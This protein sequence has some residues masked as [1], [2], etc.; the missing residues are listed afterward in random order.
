MSCD[1]C[2]KYEH[3]GKIVYFRWGVANIGLIGC[4]KHLK[5]VMAVIREHQNKLR[6]NYNENN[7]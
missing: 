1:E 2:D 4:P 7:N 3:D 6:G 5:E